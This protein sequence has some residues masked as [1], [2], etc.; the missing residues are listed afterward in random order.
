MAKQNIRV[1]TPN[2]IGDFITLYRVFELPP[3]EEAYSDEFLVEEYNNL[4][5]L[6]SV[7]GYYIDD[8]CVGLITYYR[9][10]NENGIVDHDHPILYEHPENVVY[11]SDVTVLSEYRGRGIGTKLME[12]MI[13]DCK[14]KGIEKI[15]MRTLPIGQSMSYGIAVKLGF[16]LLENVTQAVIQ[17][18]VNEE[19]NEEDVRIFLEKN[20]K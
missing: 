8:K 20:L 12:Y 13:V 5:A 19:R 3:Y 6:G 16:K 1:I 15:Y 14:S 4:R 11:F 18:R 9:S 17:E 10:A 2:K 7:Y